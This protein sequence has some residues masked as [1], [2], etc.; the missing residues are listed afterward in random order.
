MCHMGESW[1]DATLR[2]RPT[3]CLT[4]AC[5]GICA[6]AVST[7]SYPTG[8]QPAFTHRQ[9]MAP[10]ASQ[11]TQQHACAAYLPKPAPFT[12][13]LGPY[14]STAL[15][16]K[17]PP[18]VL[19]TVPTANPP[20]ARLLPTCSTATSVCD[21]LLRRNEGRPVLRSTQSRCSHVSSAP[22]ICTPH[23]DTYRN[24]HVCHA[25]SLCPVCCCYCAHFQKSF[26]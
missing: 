20:P 25:E 13:S 5:S 22:L 2:P 4:P 21:S 19:P 8:R 3:A 12:V 16:V 6:A 10:A 15:P 1:P 14:Q 24:A 11:A 18:H 7:L 23:T 17:Q 26:I 9:S